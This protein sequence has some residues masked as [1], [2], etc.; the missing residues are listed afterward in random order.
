V[1]LLL[2]GMQLQP[3]DCPVW[4][5]KVGLCSALPDSTR[6]T[7]TGIEITPDAAVITSTTYPEAEDPIAL[8]QGV[9][10]PDLLVSYSTEMMSIVRLHPKL[11]H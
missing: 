3:K 1:L 9:D 7:I 4:L 11:T 10:A 5:S 8:Q 6:A 2:T